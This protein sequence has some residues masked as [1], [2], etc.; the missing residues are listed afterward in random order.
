[1][2]MTRISAEEFINMLP[3]RHQIKA[4]EY[5]IPNKRPPMELYIHNPWDVNGKPSSFVIAVMRDPSSNSV[6]SA[7]AKCDRYTDEFS[8]KQGSRVAVNRV[9]R[10]FTDRMPLYGRDHQRRE[11]PVMRPVKVIFTRFTNPTPMNFHPLPNFVKEILS[12][13]HNL[14][15][16]V[17]GAVDINKLS[18]RGKDETI[19]TAH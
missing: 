14:L 3:V 18:K 6:F 15:K 8:F 5:L 9:F 12:R 7:S 1:M 19:K 2:K 10:E 17:A 4:M 16:R 11:Q 13:R